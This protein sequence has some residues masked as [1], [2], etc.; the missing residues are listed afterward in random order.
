M[1]HIR[2]I[3]LI[4]GLAF[5]VLALLIAG[6]AINSIL[7]LRA[8]DK[9]FSS[10]INNYNRKISVV[11]ETQVAAHM[12]VDSLS[13]MALSDDPF[14]RDAVFLE[15]NRAGFLVGSGRKALRELG[16]TPA[17]QAVFDAQTRLIA[18][19]EPVQDKVIELLQAGRDAAARAVFM[20]EAVPLQ[21]EFNRQL[22]DMRALYHQ[23]NL[24][25]QV[26]AQHTYQDAFVLTLVF[27]LSAILLALLIA[28]SSLS[29]VRRYARRIREQMHELE[30][31]RAALREEATH[32][33]LTGLA[34]RRLF[35]DRLQQAIRY[36]HRYDVKIGVL[37]LDLDQFKMTNDVYG[38]HVGD[39]VLTEVARKLSASV[40]GSDT[41]ARLGGDEFAVLIEGVSDRNDLYAAARKIEQSLGIDSPLAAL[42]V[43]IGVSI[44]H[45][46]YPDD[47][48]EEDVLM[49]AADAAMYRVKTDRG[50]ERQSELPFTDARAS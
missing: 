17:E 26:R 19:I 21:Q 22:A 30:I 29:R 8:I 10:V 44:G 9:Q 28:W 42:G 25:A 7:Q 39:A 12:R 6:L 15:Y 5:I 1:F 38:H 23:A 35:Y 16:F 13:R 41:P 11:T 49:R 4:I 3:P 50:A 34:N 33:P 31:S 47:G 48:L 37:Y 45:A 40:R 2:G 27:G 18:R 20:K 46:M 24:R 14:E 43:E 32:D 36:A